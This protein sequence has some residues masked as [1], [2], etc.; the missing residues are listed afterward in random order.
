MPLHTADSLSSSLLHGC[1]Q[2]RA[3]LHQSQ[4]P[5]FLS[6]QVP[7]EQ[8]VGTNSKKLELLSQIQE[9]LADQVSDCM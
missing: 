8:L 2:E 3:S 5:A 1:Q 4:V 9:F 6:G 7:L